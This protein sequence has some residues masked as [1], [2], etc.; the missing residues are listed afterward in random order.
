VAEKEVEQ[1]SA[2]HIHA[3]AEYILTK[4]L[5]RTDG[6]TRQLDL[7]RLIKSLIFYSTHQ[8]HKTAR[9]RLH[10][11]METYLD[12]SRVVGS[13]KDH[14]VDKTLE[15]ESGGKVTHQCDEFF[16]DPEEIPEVTE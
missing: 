4:G 10:G 15:E 14:F 2:D 13:L 6:N 16:A 8:H 7:I 12:L 3:V 9:G 11:F 1:L 5:A